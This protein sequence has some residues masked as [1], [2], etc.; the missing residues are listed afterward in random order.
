MFP[1]VRGVVARLRPLLE[2]KLESR[3]LAYPWWVPAVSYAGLVVVVVASL[4]QRHAFTPPRPVALILVLV[5]VAP[6]ALFVKPKWT[7]WWW[8]D[9]PLVLGAATWLLIG[10][11]LDVAGPADVAP[12]LLMVLVAV[13][14]ARD[15]VAPGLGMGVASI[16]LLVAAAVVVDLPSP[17]MYS[18]EVVLGL[19]VGFLLRWQM[20]ALTAERQARAGDRARA[21]AAER[22]RIAREIHDL[23]AH[24]LSVTLLHLTG[25]RQALR[26]GETAEAAE[27]L[28]DAERIGRQAMADIR[29]TVSGLTTGP[30]SVRP[31]PVAGDIGVLVEQFR[32]AGLQVD[33][34][35]PADLDRLPPGHGLGLYR[36]AQEA[37]A[38]V[39]KHAPGSRVSVTLELTP[40]EVRLV[41]C[42]GLPGGRTSPHDG[43]SGVPGM[44]ARATGLGG[45]I[46]VG[47]QEGAWVVDVRLPLEGDSAC[48][49]GRR[50]NLPE[51]APG[52][53]S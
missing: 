1:L 41:V 21:T 7:G 19:V 8:A 46:R 2:T 12:G 42:S 32:A 20:R 3:G 6:V 50:R 40:A 11:P 27:A 47:P 34:S 23:V 36:V 18:L 29:Q 28:D 26:D 33:D 38:N 10:D 22:E 49:L 4:I 48:L 37:L 24:S 51:P 53:A 5:L 17:G 13:V 31:L 45:T 43:G 16:L 25:A 14:L 30:A 9:G 39:A 52:T 44:T 15:G 35:L